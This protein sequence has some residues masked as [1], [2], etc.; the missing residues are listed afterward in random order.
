[1][2]LV[3]NDEYHSV[4]HR[5]RIKSSEEAR[6]SVAVFYN[7]TSDSELLGPFPELIT[8]E[9]PARYMSFTMQEFKDSRT[10]FGHGRSSTDHFKCC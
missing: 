2:Q 9:K 4:E 8:A 5:V 3:S 10:K 6:V 1:L 7:P